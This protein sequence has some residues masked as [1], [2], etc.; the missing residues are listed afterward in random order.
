MK[1]KKTPQLPREG[2]PHVLPCVFLLCHSLQLKGRFNIICRPSP[3]KMSKN[4]EKDDDMGP[5][6]LQQQPSLHRADNQFATLAEGLNQGLS[7][8]LH[9]QADL[10]AGTLKSSSSMN[11]NE[12]NP[13]LNGGQLRAQLL[14]SRAGCQQCNDS[15]STFTAIV[16]NPVYSIRGMGKWALRVWDIV[17]NWPGLR[18]GRVLC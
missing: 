12:E 17:L 11:L 18:Q 8:L 15:S 6:G 7:T 2:I 16:Y 5:Q 14:I 3:I 13:I 10:W 1:E 9:K 4:A